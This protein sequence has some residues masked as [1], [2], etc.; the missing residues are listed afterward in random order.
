MSKFHNKF[1]GKDVIILFYEEIKHYVGFLL[2]VKF[3]LFM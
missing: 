2:Y 1:W 3:K